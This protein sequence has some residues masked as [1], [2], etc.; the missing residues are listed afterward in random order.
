MTK[1]YEDIKNDFES[2]DC[3]LLTTEEEYNDKIKSKTVKTFRIKYKCGHIIDN[4]YYHMFM[5]R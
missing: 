1:S 5:S 3:K 4:C 2:K